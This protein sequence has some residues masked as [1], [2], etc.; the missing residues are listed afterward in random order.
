M[1]HLF[2]TSSRIA[3]VIEHSYGSSRTR[4]L[5]P[6]TP[7]PP[8]NGVSA[9]AGRSGLSGAPSPASQL[10]AAPDA[11]LERR[12]QRATR[13]HVTDSEIRQPISHTAMDSTRARSHTAA[14]IQGALESLSASSQLEVVAVREEPAQGGSRAQWPQ[15]LDARVIGAFAEKG[16]S[17]PWAHQRAAFD[18]LHEGGDLVIATQTASGKS[19]CYQVPI[20]HTVLADPHAR[21]LALFPTKALARDQSAS[22]RER[23]AAALGVGLGVFDGDTPP[24]ERQAVRTRA[25]MIATNPDMLHRAILPGHDR[26]ASVL[27]NLRYVVIDELHVYRGVFGSHVANVLRRLLRLCEHYGSRPQLIGCSATIANPGQL[28]S[29]LTGR[30]DACL[31]DASAAPR[32]QRTFAVV[33]PAI[34][35]AATGLRRDFLKVSRAVARELRA[36]ELGTLAFCR[37]RKAVELLTRYV[38]EDDIAQCAGLGAAADEHGTGPHPDHQLGG[39]VTPSVRARAERSVRGYRG[40]YLPAH[41]REVEAALRSGEAELVATTSALELGLDIGAVDAVLL[42]GYPG[43]RAATWQRSGRAGRRDTPALTIMV[44]SSAPL[45]QRVAECPELLFDGPIERAMIDADNPEILIPHLRCAAFELPLRA[46]ESFGAPSNDCGDHGEHGLEPVLVHLEQRGVL[47]RV[48]APS[49]STWHSIGT[50]FP[51]EDVDLRGTLEE[52]FQVIERCEGRLEDGRVLAEVDFEDA[53]MYLH[54]GAIYPMEGRNYEVLALDWD[55]RKATVAKVEVAYYTEAIC[56]LRVRVLDSLAASPV[57]GHGYVQ[58]VRSVPAFKKIRFTSHETLG[59]GPVDLPDLDMQSCGVWWDLPDTLLA[60]F[61]EAGERT[62]VVFALSHV[63]RDAGLLVLMCE[64]G[65]LGAVIGAH[66]GT[67]AWAV[68]AGPSL[69]PNAASEASGRPSILLYD[70]RPGGAGL[71]IAIAEQR[72]TVLE[73]ALRLALGATTRERARGQTT[74][75]EIGSERVVAA[76]RCLIDHAATHAREDPCD[77]RAHNDSEDLLNEHLEDSRA[78][79]SA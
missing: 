8:S 77:G 16:I 24:D 54:V 70:K 27:A 14:R 67:G 76:L 74:G 36:H 15:W 71:A 42:A 19:L 6:E 39:P 49:G 12:G 53:P 11:D 10:H 56:H 43:T 41:R 35:D 44:M 33:N 46:D 64:P 57:G 1:V 75:R 60:D 61:P 4:G 69:T 38:R 66:L 58:V 72:D 48:D 68:V 26:F 22:L 65:D 52:N 21:A 5:L 50:P 9:R 78:T 31:I 34:C 30:P 73:V 20:L 47:A 2:S 55:A 25:H 18:A 79:S 28:F 29:L 3:S 13:E 37:T 7:D 45:D 62:Q 40:G 32:P 23:A 63:L 59:F 17:H 51:A